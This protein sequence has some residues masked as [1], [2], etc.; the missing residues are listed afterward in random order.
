MD[1][2]PTSTTLLSKLPLRQTVA[3]PALPPLP[4]LSPH[5]PIMECV[6][7]KLGRHGANTNLVD[8][9][10]KSLVNLMFKALPTM[11]RFEFEKVEL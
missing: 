9:V 7:V 5:P 11:S 4:R 6:Y 1:C 3:L 10:P 2:L 8:M